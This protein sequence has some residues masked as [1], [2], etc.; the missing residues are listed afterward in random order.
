MGEIRRTSEIAMNAGED[1]MERRKGLVIGAG[2]VSEKRAAEKCVS[3][4]LMDKKEIN[5]TKLTVNFLF[6]I[7]GVFMFLLFALLAH[8][9]WRLF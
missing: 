5:S 1:A 8:F 9:V 7:G 6:W 2:S 4:R 3:V